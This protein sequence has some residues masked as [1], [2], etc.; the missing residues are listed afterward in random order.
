MPLR[1]G[2]K[3]ES[4]LKAYIYLMIETLLPDCLLVDQKKKHDFGF[5]ML[6]LWADKGACRRGWVSVVEE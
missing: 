2:R 4:D 1:P 5:K 3:C 6:E